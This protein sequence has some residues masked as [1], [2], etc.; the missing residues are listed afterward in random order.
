V[1][2]LSRHRWEPQGPR[3]AGGGEPVARSKLAGARIAAVTR[4]W[5]PTHDSSSAA[6]VTTS[7]DP[8]AATARGN[9]GTALRSTRDHQP[10]HPPPTTRPEHPRPGPDHRLFGARSIPWWPALS[11][12]LVPI[13]R[14]W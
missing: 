8:R 3:G 2:N 7:T 14:Y 4:P 10:P 12:L 6:G 11:L 5:R 1:K 13:T 9:R